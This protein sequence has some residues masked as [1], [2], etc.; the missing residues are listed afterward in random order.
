M[1]K[2]VQAWQLLLQNRSSNGLPPT[3]T[4]SLTVPRASTPTSLSRSASPLASVARHSPSPVSPSTRQELVSSPVKH[5]PNVLT[6]SSSVP[7]PVNN[8]FP[9]SESNAS[10]PSRSGGS[11]PA[12]NR[13]KLLTLLSKVR[14]PPNQTQ[15]LPTASQEEDPHSSLTI[16][17]PVPGKSIQTV[18]ISVEESSEGTEMSS[19]FSGINFVS[20]VNDKSSLEDAVTSVPSDSLASLAGYVEPKPTATSL[21]LP[22]MLPFESKQES[23]RKAG[24]TANKSHREQR[25]LKPAEEQLVVSFPRNLVKSNSTFNHNFNFSNHSSYKTDDTTPVTV[26]GGELQSLMVSIPIHCLQQTPITPKQ[27]AKRHFW[28]NKAS[29]IDTSPSPSGPLTGHAQSN[30]VQKATLS[31]KVLTKCDWEDENQVDAGEVPLNRPD[32]FPALLPVPC[33]NNEHHQT[34]EENGLVPSSDVGMSSVDV[35][36]GAEPGVSGMVGR[37][38]E[39]FSWT[40][41]IPTS[42]D[43]T[44]TVLP[45]V[46]ID[47]VTELP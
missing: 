15:C 47:D 2:L 26:C 38:G 10:G 46:F 9:K 43:N 17:N 29:P 24:M 45:Y 6:V 14:K 41:H 27:N 28:T 19:V 42:T 11:D 33:A 13:I 16:Q 3:P 18:S 36:G 34:R 25:R 20:E 12:K 8:L 30:G 5:D 37:S 22:I 40:E 31:G 4:S 7:K 35:L 1:K 44:V 21:S 39:W 23:P 32:S